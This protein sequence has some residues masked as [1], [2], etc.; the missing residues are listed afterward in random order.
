MIG[1]ATSAATAE[2][3]TPN[4]HA[5]SQIINR[6]FFIV[7]FNVNDRRLT[8]GRGHMDAHPVL[9]SE[10]DNGTK[11][12]NAIRE[13]ESTRAGK[14]IEVNRWEKAWQIARRK[15]LLAVV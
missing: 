2:S 5:L 14:R 9:E 7:Q 3:Q 13:W 12:P 10:C 11:G 4:A 6:V 15:S 8:N 1:C